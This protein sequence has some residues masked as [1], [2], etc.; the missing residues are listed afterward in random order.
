M[1]LLRQLL[2]SHNVQAVSKLEQTAMLLN[3]VRSATPPALHA[4]LDEQGRITRWSSKQKD[5]Q[6][7]LAYLVEKF[8]P[9][10]SYS[11]REVNDLLQQ[12]YL[13]ADYVLVR[14]SLID[15]GLLRRTKDGAR[16]WRDAGRL[17]ISSRS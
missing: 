5:Q 9:E 10:H 8:E 3:Q 7:M 14:R 1:F 2:S 15:S 11:E 13:D 16:Y 17:E 12:W 6:A 4:L